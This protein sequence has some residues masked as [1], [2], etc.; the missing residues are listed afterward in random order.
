M[1]GV[2]MSKFGKTA[3]AAVA[4]AMVGSTLFGG[5]ALASDTHHHVKRDI[6]VTNT[7]GAGGA[8][9]GA[10]NNCLNLAAQVPVLNLFGS[11]PANSAAC[12]ATGG[13]GGAGGA[14][15]AY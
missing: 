6:D 14:G 1:I 3:V 4:F 2:T 12:T 5:A 9:G 10:E 15:A 7:G 11:D 8:G 13:A